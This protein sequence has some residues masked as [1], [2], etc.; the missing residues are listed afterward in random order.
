MIDY[1]NWL[2]RIILYS[3]ILQVLAKVNV[4][5]KVKVRVILTLKFYISSLNVHRGMLFSKFYQ[6]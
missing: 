2:K 5:V 4:K 1:L 3:S 6:I